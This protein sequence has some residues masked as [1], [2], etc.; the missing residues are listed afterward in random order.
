MWRRIERHGADCGHAGDSGW[1]RIAGRRVVLHSQRG[2]PLQVSLDNFDG[3]RGEELGLLEAYRKADWHKE[4]KL[5]R[6]FDG[7]QELVRA[8][9][10]HGTQLGS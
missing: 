8:L 2:I 10:A 6:A 9:Q 1:H 4:L 5:L 7:V 3:G